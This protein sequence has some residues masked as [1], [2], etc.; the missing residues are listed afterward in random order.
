MRLQHTKE[1]LHKEF[2]INSY[3]QAEEIRSVELNTSVIFHVH[4]KNVKFLRTVTCKICVT[5]VGILHSS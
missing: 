5:G 2:K 1:I 3:F 4:S